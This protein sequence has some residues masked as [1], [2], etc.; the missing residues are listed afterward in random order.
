MITMR[1]MKVPLYPI[2]IRI[3]IYDESSEVHDKYDIADG[4][5]KGF[6]DVSGESGTK[7]F[8]IGIKSE[9]GVS[10]IAHEC[11]HAKNRIFAFVNYSCDRQNDEPDAYLMGWLA[12]TV[13]NVYYKHKDKKL[14]NTDKS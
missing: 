14:K 4:N 6:F 8:V 13:T 10:T 2:M 9:Y 7:D 5:E 12:K 1:R 11:E 3:V